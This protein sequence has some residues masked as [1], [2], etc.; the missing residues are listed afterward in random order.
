[1]TPSDEVY[2]RNHYLVPS[3]DEDFEEEFEL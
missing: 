2:V 1:L 3:F